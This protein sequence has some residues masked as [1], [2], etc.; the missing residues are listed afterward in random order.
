MK[1][2]TALLLLAAMLGLLTAHVGAQTLYECKDA[3]GNVRFSDRA[4]T[5][6]VRAVPAPSDP[7]SADSKAASDARVQNDK[8]L[9]NRIE[10]DRLATEQASRAVQDQQTQAS[11][12]AASKVEQ[13]RAQKSSNTS[14]L[15]P[16]GTV[17]TPPNQ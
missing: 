11:R 9:A 6:L 15:Q 2:P 4:C 7:V 5:G 12:A 10:A 17:F 3:S 14:A 8:A 13:E 1:H 16:S